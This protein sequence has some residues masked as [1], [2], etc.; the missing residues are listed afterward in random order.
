MA[1]EQMFEN[2]MEKV[3]AYIKQSGELT[4][5]SDGERRYGN[6]LFDICAEVLRTGSRG[7]PP[8]TLPLG[9]YSTA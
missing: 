8:K 1:N 3:A 7:R 6:T 5:L 4:F 2:A 9:V